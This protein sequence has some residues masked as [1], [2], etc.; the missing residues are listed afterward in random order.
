MRVN[1]GLMLIVLCLGTAVAMAVSGQNEDNSGIVGAVERSNSHTNQRTDLPDQS[2]TDIHLDLS[3]IKRTVPKSIGSGG[4]FQSK[5]WYVPPA[6]PPSKSLS[7]STSS[8]PLQPTAPTLPFTF[9]GR[10][11]DG[12]D[13]VLFLLKN[14]QQYSVRTNDTLDGTYRVDEITDKLAV[15]TY[16]PMNMQ[17]TLLFNSSAVIKPGVNTLADATQIPITPELPRQIKPSP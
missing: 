13:V 8:V 5:S 11:I 2:R 12:K 10:M 9:I 6:L 1:P 7:S 14:G 17:Q 4:L 16:L 15:L 3:A